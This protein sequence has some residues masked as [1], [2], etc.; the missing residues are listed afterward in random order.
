MKQVLASKKSKV[1]AAVATLFVLLVAGATGVFFYYGSHALPGTKLAGHAVGGQTRAEVRETI[2]ALVADQ[3]VELV[4]PDGEST[5]VD[6][7]EAG[8]F[9]DAARSVDAVF[10]ANGNFAS[11][12]K[13]IFSSPEVE[14]V[15]VANYALLDDYASAIESSDEVAA[16]D[17]QVSFDPELASFTVSESAIGL[18]IDT[19]AVE[20]A[21][22]LAAGTLSDAVITASLIDVEPDM[23]TDVAQVA[24]DS[25]NAWLA[26]DIQTTDADGSVATAEPA[27][28]ASW[29]EFVPKEDALDAKIKEDAVEE[30]VTTFAEA[31]NREVENGVQNVNSTGAVVSTPK[32]GVAGRAVE[33]AEAIAEAIVA[34]FESGSSFSGEFAYTVIEPTYDQRLIAD[35]A[36]LLA[37]PAAPGERWIDIDLSNYSVTG[38]EGATPVVRTPMVPGAPL[39]PTKTGSFAVYAKLPSQTMRGNNVDGSTYE[40]PNVPWILY[41][42]GGYALHGAYWRSSFGYDAGSGGSHGCVN[43]PVGQAK[44]LYDFA[45]IGDKVIV[46]Y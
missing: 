25:A 24:A 39:T 9:I 45:S 13:G 16:V 32:E 21:L 44:Q 7:V 37:Y 34:A 42:D 10:E 35:G 20:E 31:S 38:Y 5:E 27:V 40:T 46:H 28:V 2:E 15:V 19:E 29:V 33:N 3:D 18:G 4:S 11:R 26:L 36:E 22:L 8:V 14:P 12:V 30:W 17:A 43:L 6:F 41:Y 23:P 1:V